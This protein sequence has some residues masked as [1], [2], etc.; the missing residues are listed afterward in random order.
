MINM[1]KAVSIICY[2]ILFFLTFLMAFMH[3]KGLVE[4]NDPSGVPYNLSATLLFYIISTNA[5]KTW[6]KMLM[7]VF[8]VLGFVS[9]ILLFFV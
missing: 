5:E 3:R 6:Y 1:K 2:L 4:F 7:S 8:T 9:C